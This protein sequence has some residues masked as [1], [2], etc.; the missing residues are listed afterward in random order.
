MIM[1]CSTK[2]LEEID[3]VMRKGLESLNMFEAV[4][5]RE[6]L[7]WSRAGTVYSYGT[8]F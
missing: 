3:M 1:S 4:E 6:E 8:I 5:E 7:G 2:K